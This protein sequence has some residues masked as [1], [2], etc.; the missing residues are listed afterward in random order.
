MTRT[1]TFVSEQ[2]LITHAPFSGSELIAMQDYRTAFESNMQTAMDAWAKAHPGGVMGAN[3]Q[4]YFPETDLKA[5][6]ARLQRMKPSER[7]R[8]DKARRYK[9]KEK[10]AA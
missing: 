10:E 4:A 6:K 3:G 7:K 1:H 2:G 8:F 5:I 9:T